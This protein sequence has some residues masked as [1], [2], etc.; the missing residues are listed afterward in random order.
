MTT[1]VDEPVVPIPADVSDKWWESLFRNSSSDVVRGH[2]PN[3]HHQLVTSEQIQ[4]VIRTA[5]GRQ[6]NPRRAAQ[7]L[8]YY[9]NVADGDYRF[10]EALTDLRQ[11]CTYADEMEYTQPS[12]ETINYAGGPLRTMFR[13]LPQPIGVHPFPY[14]GI[15]LTSTGPRGSVWGY[16]PGGEEEVEYTFLERGTVGPPRTIQVQE[17]G[18]FMK[19]V[20]GIV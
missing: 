6:V 4:E 9:V 7:L 20:Q 10:R 17:L 1:W 11:I 8:R 18:D 13:T 5:W 16:C 3:R 19:Q 14:G 2:R 12:Q 15:V